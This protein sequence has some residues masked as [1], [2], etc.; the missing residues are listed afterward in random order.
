[1]AGAPREEEASL[2]ADEIIE[3]IR[4]ALQGQP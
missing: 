4:L 1:M 3:A 2:T